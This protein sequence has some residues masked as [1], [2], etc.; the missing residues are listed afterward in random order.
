MTTNEIPVSLLRKLI[1]YNSETGSCV[2]LPRDPGMFE[3]G[4]K[5][6]REHICKKWN[7][8]F[9]GKEVGCDDKDGYRVASVFGV[10]LKAHRMVW[11]LVMG[12]WPTGEID[13]DDTDT[14]NNRW[15]NLRDASRQ[16]NSANKVKYA[17]NTSGLKRVSWS[18]TMQKWESRIEAGGKNVVLCYSDCRAVASFGRAV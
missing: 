6:T 11:A 4:P 13:H 5:Q 17:N 9:A 2:W 18:K 16:Q 10:Y 15:E 3:N 14:A 8:R 7:T 1:S 12:E